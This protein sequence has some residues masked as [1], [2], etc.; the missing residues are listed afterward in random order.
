MFEALRVPMLGSSSL[1]GKTPT[2][3]ATVP[4]VSPQVN[5][6]DVPFLAQSSRLACLFAGDVWIIA[7]QVD[8]VTSLRDYG[9]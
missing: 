5:H 2:I 7:I 8:V 3:L 6:T 1:P 4:N 9:S